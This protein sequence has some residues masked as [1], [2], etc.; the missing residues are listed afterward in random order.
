[1]RFLEGCLPVGSAVGVVTLEVAAAIAPAKVALPP[2]SEEDLAMDLMAAE[3][4]PSSV[5]DR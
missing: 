1:M 4:A 5:F 2:V 3:L